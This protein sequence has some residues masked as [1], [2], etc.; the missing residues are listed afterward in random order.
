MQKWFLKRLLAVAFLVPGAA[1]GAE[2]PVAAGVDFVSVENTKRLPARL[3]AQRTALGV[4]GDYKPCV[5]K[6]PNGELVLVAFNQQ[7]QSRSRAGLRPAKFREDIVLFRSKDRGVTW[8]PRQVIQDRAGREPYLTVL[9]DGTLFMTTHMNYSEVR[10]D[11]GTIYSYVHRSAD[12]A[13]TWQTLRIDWRD[14]PGT[15]L[16]RS[17]PAKECLIR[18]RQEYNLPNRLPVID[19]QALPPRDFQLARIDP[20]LLQDGRVDIGDVM[21]VLDGVEAD[22]VGS[23]VDDAALDAATG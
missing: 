15:P 1:P 23:A 20:Q 8:S 18:G 16:K 22:G 14:V 21:T 3:L 11:D 19:L 10:N 4:A 12:G 2:E 17:S 5:A 13:R 9:A 7:P 6:L